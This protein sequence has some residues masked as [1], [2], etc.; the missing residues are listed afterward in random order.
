MY[1]QRKTPLIHYV[2]QNLYIDIPILSKVNTIAPVYPHFTAR[3]QLAR[4]V[5]TIVV[6]LLVATSGC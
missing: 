5:L 1:I 2:N 3:T 4:A 6:N